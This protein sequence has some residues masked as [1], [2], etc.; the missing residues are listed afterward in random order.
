MESAF[1]PWRKSLTFVVL[2]R[3]LSGV[4]SAAALRDFLNSGQAG[5]ER[6]SLRG[7]LIIRQVHGT[8]DLTGLPVGSDIRDGVMVSHLESYFN[9]AKLVM[10]GPFPPVEPDQ[11]AESVQRHAWICR[12]GDPRLG[13][14]ER[15]EE[16][17]PLE[18][19]YDS[20]RR[21]VLWIRSLKR[22]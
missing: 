6:P 19:G 11:Q 15:F 7:R 21:V 17:V 5:P 16:T 3:V 10:Q 13:M 1:L 8:Q 18:L 12:D 22:Q 14:V 4:G 2:A 9:K 20:Y